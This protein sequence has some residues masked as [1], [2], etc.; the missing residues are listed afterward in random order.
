[1]A[2]NAGATFV[3]ITAALEGGTSHTEDIIVTLTLSGTADD[4]DYAVSNL[5]SITIPAGRFSESRSLIITPVDDAII[6]ETETILITG[7]TP[8]MG[9]RTDT[10][11]LTDATDTQGNGVNAYLSISDQ[12]VTTPEGATVEL[13]VMLSH[14]IAADVNVVCQVTPG[15]ADEA[16]YV[17]PPGAVV[18]FPADS[19]RR[20]NTDHRDSHQP[21]HAFRRGGKLYG[22]AWSRVGRSGVPG[23]GEPDQ[24]QR[25]CDDSRE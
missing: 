11:L 24:R 17:H 14:S 7:S 13:T 12:S 23:F 10:I 25:Y 3:T 21:G 9:D 5:G 8:G 19:R 16:D 1:M 4:S 6:E 18:T 22:S 2:E 15:S 20:R